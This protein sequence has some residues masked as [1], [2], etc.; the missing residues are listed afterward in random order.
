MSNRARRPDVRQADENLVSTQRAACLSIKRRYNNREYD[1][2]DPSSLLPIGLGGFRFGVCSPTD[3]AR[4]VG[5]LE[6]DILLPRPLSHSHCII[7]VTCQSLVRNYLLNSF[8]VRML[9]SIWPTVPRE[10]LLPRYVGSCCFLRAGRYPQHRHRM[11]TP[12]CCPLTYNVPLVH[13]QYT[14]HNIFSSFSSSEKLPV[15]LEPL[16]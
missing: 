15:S 8:T 7:F 10:K 5:A 4:S 6:T 12:T 2:D 16:P 14:N 1:H 3:T 11:R 9:L 13:T